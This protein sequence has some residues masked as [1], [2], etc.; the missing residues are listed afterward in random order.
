MTA[1]LTVG[2]TVADDPAGGADLD[3]GAAMERG[4]VNSAPRIE[5]FERA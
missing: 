3:L 4:G 2:H 1:T 5:I